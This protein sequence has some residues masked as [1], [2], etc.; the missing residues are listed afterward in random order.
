MA[1][2]KGMHARVVGIIRYIVH[3]YCFSLKYHY[4][5]SCRDVLCTLLSLLA[6]L[7]CILFLSA[8]PTSPFNFCVSIYHMLEHRSFF[9]TSMKKK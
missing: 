5:K 4:L 3:P 7:A 2:K 8:I 9:T 1:D 6:T